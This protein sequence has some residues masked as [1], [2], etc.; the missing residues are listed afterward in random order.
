MASRQCQGTLKLE[1]KPS[2]F[3]SETVM[4][5]LHIAVSRYHDRTLLSVLLLSPVLFHSVSGLL[6]TSSTCMSI[7]L[8]PGSRYA[9]SVPTR[10][11]RAR[12]QTLVAG[13]LWY[14]PKATTGNRV[15]GPI[16]SEIS[17][18]CL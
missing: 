11:P 2:N 17:G 4:V 10:T 1:I 5:K 18:F 8:V 7:T 6:E 13:S 15:P 9:Q 12:R 16:W 14:T 3:D